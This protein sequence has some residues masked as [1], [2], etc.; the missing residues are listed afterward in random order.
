MCLEE[1]LRVGLTLAKL[2]ASCTALVGWVLA[3]RDSRRSPGRGRP[4]PQFIS[5]KQMRC[6]HTEGGQSTECPARHH[7]KAVHAPGPAPHTRLARGRPSNSRLPGRAPHVRPGEGAVHPSKGLPGA[8]PCPPAPPGSL[9]PPRGWS[10]TLLSDQDQTHDSTPAWGW[11]QAVKGA[12]VH[13]CAGCSV[14]QPQNYRTSIT[15]VKSLSKVMF[16][17]SGGGVH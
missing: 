5:S 17:K 11:V 2:G 6:Q 15:S 12:T 1:R 16:T 7:R 8:R 3:I 10:S 9:G 4:P 14:A 13:P